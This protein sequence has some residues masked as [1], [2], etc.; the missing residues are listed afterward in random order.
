MFLAEPE[1]YLRLYSKSSSLTVIMVSLR[2]TISGFTRSR[3]III[4][5]F[6]LMKPHFGAKRRRRRTEAFTSIILIVFRRHMLPVCHHWEWLQRNT[7]PFFFFFS[8]SS[9]LSVS[10]SCKI[11]I[12]QSKWDDHVQLVHSCS[13]VLNRLVSR[14][15]YT[16]LKS[17]LLWVRD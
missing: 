12:T 5:S 11:N 10:I 16:T 13:R 17:L 8:S 7:L 6:P 4:F 9:F 2:A 1:S 15:R 3:S 14:A